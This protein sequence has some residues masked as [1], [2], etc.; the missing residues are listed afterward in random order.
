[1]TFSG[2]YHKYPLFLISYFVGVKV[3]KMVYNSGGV[4]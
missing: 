3:V 1:M 2:V 4:L